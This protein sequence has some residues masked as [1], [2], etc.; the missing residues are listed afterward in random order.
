MTARPDPLA[1]YLDVL[2]ARAR[3]STLVETRWRVPAGMG[4]RFLA[5]SDRARIERTVLGFGEST[6]VYVGVL[7]R[8]RRAGGREGIV[9]DARTVWVD[10][11]IETAARALEP[12]EPAP[13]LVVASGGSGHLHAYWTLARAV[14]PPVIERANRRLAWALGGDLASTDAPRILRPPSTL[15]HGRGRAPV[16]LAAGAPGACRLGP[17]VGGLLDPPETTPRTPPDRNR[18]RG[19]T[20]DPLLALA[21]ERYVSVLTGQRVAAGRKV[22]CPLHDDRT[23]SLHVYADPQRGWFCFGC[24]RGGSVYDLASGLWS[25]EPR[26]RGFVALR[27]ELLRLFA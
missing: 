17:L 25:V 19:A 26:G 9:G 6:D 18:R 21:P 11:D 24:R 20:P 2:F 16:T 8:W 13:T 15:H 3:P 10:L 27:E 22:C 7:P 14:P 23:A 1:L 4:R 5:T 12:V